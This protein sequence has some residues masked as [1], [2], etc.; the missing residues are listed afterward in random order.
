M[1]FKGRFNKN[2]DSKGRLAV[3]AP[4]RETLE[5]M[6]VDNLVVTCTDRCLE[7]FPDNEWG[8]L[9]R[10]FDRLP[11]M[12]EDVELFQLFYI[13]SAMDVS[14]DKQGRILVPQALRKQVNLKKEIVVVGNFIKIQVYAQEVWNKV[15]EEASKR[16][17]EISNRLS[18]DL[19]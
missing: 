6:G 3:P 2:L 12:R 18:E 5:S 13:S 4:M 11:S 14:L 1:K 16:F 10:K 7:I 9:L 15:A 8:K 19:A 17:R